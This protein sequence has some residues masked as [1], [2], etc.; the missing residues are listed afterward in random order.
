MCFSA[1]ASFVAAAALTVIGVVSIRGAQS[2]RHA[3][4]AAIPLLFAA[5]QACEGVVWLV[6]E[7]A[8]YH[9]ASTPLARAFLFFALFVWPPYVPVALA[10]VE[11]IRARRVLLLV[12]GALGAALGAYLMACASLRASN[13]C[14]AY[15]NLYY[16]VQV[17]AP[18]KPVML[19][20]YL[21]IIV[22]ALLASSVRKTSM[23]AGLVAVSFVL[24]GVLYRA[25][26]ASVWCF[27]AAL[28]S[29]AFVL[30]QSR[31]G[32]PPPKPPTLRDSRSRPSP[33]TFARGSRAS[34]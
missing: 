23:I 26:F 24:T 22:S 28:L 9:V 10:L 12:L 15:G 3:P 17:D 31:W 29:G 16:W 32:A 14:I 21:G 18:L 8:P 6:L 2:R 33:E 5:Q 34:R 30:A 13:A 19:V 11:G 7:R 1:R 27:F 4:L 20:L 25:G